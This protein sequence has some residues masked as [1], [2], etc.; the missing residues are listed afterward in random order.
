MIHERVTVSS[1]G[2]TIHGFYECIT[3]NSTFFK[4]QEGAK[5]FS[6]SFK[7]NKIQLLM[8]WLF[9][10]FSLLW[11]TPCWSRWMW[12]ERSY[13]P[14]RG[15]HSGA[16]FLAGTMAHGIHLCWSSLCLK[17]CAPWKGLNAAAVLEELQH[18]G[19]THIAVVHEGLSSV[20]GT[21]CGV[22]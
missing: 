10:T 19:R 7:I 20:G 13:S 15:A 9:I 4:T 17:D 16:G 1:D 5:G 14:W 11:K 21:P 22:E 12:L 6:S 2:L 3:N 18:V 8:Y